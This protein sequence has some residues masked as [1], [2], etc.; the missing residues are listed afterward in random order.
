MVLPGSCAWHVRARARMP[1]PPL[2][3]HV[4]WPLRYRLRYVALEGNKLKL[5]QV[6][7]RMMYGNFGIILDHFSRVSQR[8]SPLPNRAVYSTTPT[9]AV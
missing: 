4:P 3:S 8:C 7:D 6:D 5:Y 2:T 9:H 1:F